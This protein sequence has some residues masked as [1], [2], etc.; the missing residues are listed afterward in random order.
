MS[1]CEKCWGDAYK[2]H[3]ADPSKSQVEHYQDL[4]AERIRKP[5]GG[6]TVRKKL[7]A[8]ERW[9]DDES[10]ILWYIKTALVVFPLVW[11]AMLTV[12][13]LIVLL[14]N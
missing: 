1:C 4:L 12:A 13:F 8:L 11:G 2:R 3:V 7:I 10:V 9:M 5:R 6:G 14:Q